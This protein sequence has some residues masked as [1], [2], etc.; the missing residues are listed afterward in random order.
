MRFQI[1]EELDKILKKID[2]N[3]REIIF[4]KIDK[5]LKNPQ[6]GKPLGYSLVV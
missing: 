1:S 2:G 4:K 3:T 5:I 6:L